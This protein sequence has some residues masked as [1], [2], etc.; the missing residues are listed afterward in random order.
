MSWQATTWAMSQ[1]VGNAGRKLLLLAL[2][3]Y[4]DENGVCWPSQGRLTLDTEA[5]LDT[6]QRQT[7]KLIEDGFL[8]VTRPPKRRGQWQTFNYQLN[9]G[10]QTAKPQNA[11]RQETPETAAPPIGYMGVGL[12]NAVRSDRI[13]SQPGRTAK[14]QSAREPSRIAVRPNPSIEHSIEP[15]REPS[16]Q[17]PRA[18]PTLGAA[19]R[20]AAWQTNQAI[21][22][23]QSRIARRLGEEGWTILMDLSETELERITTLECKSRLTDEELSRT[24][25]AN[26]RPELRSG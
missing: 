8:S 11:A 15:S 3:N 6:V 12:P 24:V 18:Q 7:K 20:R 2:A 23:V 19:A 16:H 17:H 14:P 9:M 13:S 21:E 4:A 10:N 22:V 25:L 1:K 5:S 26:G